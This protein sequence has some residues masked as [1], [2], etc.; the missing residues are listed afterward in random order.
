MKV[1]LG[2]D[3]LDYSCVANFNCRNLKQQSCGYTD[4]AEFSEL[5]TVILWSSF[6]AERN[7]E[8]EIMDQGVLWSFK[9][10]GEQTF[11][12][13]FNSYKALDVPGFTYEE[14]LHQEERQRLKAFFDKKGT[15][16]EYDRIAFSNHQRNKEIFLSMLNEDCDIQMGYFALADAIGHLSFGVTSKMR[17]IYQELD[18]LAAHVAKKSKGGLLILSD[19]GMEPVGRFGDHSRRGFW[20]FSNAASNKDNLRLTQLFRIFMDTIKAEATDG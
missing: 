16:E 19:H 12:S 15:L 2:L 8:K 4:L 9:L 18:D 3:G 14:A 13:R 10:P 11:F 7:M 1:I 5:K 20:S 17:I 6:L